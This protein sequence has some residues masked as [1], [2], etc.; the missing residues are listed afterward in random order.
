[1]VSN[2]QVKL[3]QVKQCQVQSGYVMLRGGGEGMG[4]GVCMGG[5]W[6]ARGGRGF[7]WVGLS[8]VRS[9]QVR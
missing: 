5:V 9:S 6:D 7:D 4:V 3:G 2:V 1:M 8:Q